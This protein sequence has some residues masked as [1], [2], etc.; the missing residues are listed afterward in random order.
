M[1]IHGE[2]DLAEQ[3]SPATPATGRAVVYV[4]SDGRLYIKDDTGVERL[5]TVA[6]AA[7]DGV[8]YV[9]AGLLANDTNDGLTWSSPKATVASAVSSLP[10]G[11]GLVK[12]SLGTFIGPIV[13]KSN[14][15]IEGLGPEMT[16]LTIANGA[17]VDVV[18]GENFDTLTRTESNGGIARWGLRNLTIDG[19]KANQTAELSTPAAPALSSATTGGS[20]A[21]ATHSYRI[22]RVNSLGTTLP[23]SVTTIATT[24]ST[25]TVTVTFPATV[26]GQTGWKVYANR[27][28]GV[29]KLVT[30][31]GLVA[32]YADNGSVTPAG[33]LPDA[34]GTAA[35][36]IRSYGYDFSWD[37]VVVRN[38]K[39]WGVYSE[40]AAGNFEILGDG[41]ESHVS[42]FSVHNNEGGGIAWR[43]P[44]DSVW[45]SGVVFKN[46]TSTAM[47][48][49]VDV[50]SGASGLR[51]YGVHVWGADCHDWAWY[52]HHTGT[53]D[54]TTI[55]LTDCIGEGGET[56]NLIIG[57]NDCSV[58]GGSYFDLGSS[59][60]PMGITVGDGVAVGGTVLLG[61]KILN[62]T[63]GAITYANDAGSTVVLD[64]YQTGG[65]VE[66]GSP[67][68][69]SRIDIRGNGSRSK[70]PGSVEATAGFSM[71]AG[72][73]LTSGTT[74]PVTLYRNAANQWR[75]DD[76]LVVVR[77]AVNAFE[78]W[79]TV[80]NWGIDTVNKVM[81]LLNGAQIR[82][83]SDQFGT[84]KYLIDAASG[85]AQFTASADSTATV[86]QGA[87]AGLGIDLTLAN[88]FLVAVTGNMTSG[89]PLQFPIKA[90]QIVTVQ[91]AQ[92][93]TGG[94]T[95]ILPTEADGS[96]V[97]WS[98]STP[99]PPTGP[100]AR[101]SVTLYWDGFDWWEIGRSQNLNPAGASAAPATDGV[102]YVS[103]TGSDSN[104]GLS[105][106]SAKLTPRAAV[107]SLAGPG[108]VYIGKGTFSITGPATQVVMPTGVVLQG[109]GI[110]STV[111]QLAA[112]ANVDA[113]KGTNFDTLRGTNGTGGVYGW[114]IRDLTIDVN[115]TNQSVGLS[116]PAAPT[117]GTPAQALVGGSLVPGVYRYRLADRNAVGPT[118]ASA[119]YVITVAAG[120]NTNVVNLVLPAAGAGAVDR[121]I[122]R[123]AV[124]GAAE[125]EQLIATVSAAT[126]TYQDTGATAP[127]GM[128]PITNMSKPAGVRVYGYDFTVENVRIRN[129]GWYSEWTNVIAGVSVADSME[130][131]IH[132]LKVHDA[133]EDGFVFNGPHDTSIVDL[134]SYQNI[135]VGIFVGPNGNA[136]FVNCHSWGLKQGEAWRIRATGVQL[137]NCVGEGAAT[138]Q[139][140][141]LGNDLVVSGGY[142]FGASVST[143][144]QQA[145]ASGDAVPF[146]RN[147]SSNADFAGLPT[148]FQ[149]QIDSED[150][151]VSGTTATTMTFSAR[152][153]NGTVAAAH[154]VGA[155]IQAPANPVGF[156]IGNTDTAVAGTKI[157]TKVNNCTSGTVRFTN[158]AGA[159]RIQI[160]GYQT[161]GPAVV[162]SPAAST[163][164]GVELNGGGTGS[165]S[166]GPVIA[167][168]T[169]GQTV[170]AT[171][172]ADDTHLSLPVMANAEYEIEVTLWVTAAATTTGAAVSLNGPASPTF[173]QFSAFGQI[174]QGASGAAS[175]IFM[176]SATA[177]NTIL[178]GASV[179]STTV[180]SMVVIKGYLSNGATAGN[181]VVRIAGEAA[182]SITYRQGSMMRLTR[183]A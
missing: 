169:A 102:R 60:A 119:A 89:N 103:A 132:N 173:L 14:V 108:I 147:I 162:G 168:K 67:H 149:V 99:V 164:L 142:Y 167:R 66:A 144:L 153:Q 155:N 115:G 117:A 69:T 114:A 183:I 163:K 55:A 110:G 170:S 86:A 95:I 63:S 41:S 145:I 181:L 85:N 81:A 70:F 92:D 17:N 180:P 128:L 73:A 40:W 1:R 109:A 141:V 46:G 156:Q 54:A 2:L 31:V 6:P 159:S 58:I 126:T 13:A 38:C 78:V 138:A 107:D 165:Q 179:A 72:Q 120:T 80:Q 42:N 94:R 105:P 5:F 33:R 87:G 175:T 16:V 48:R 150:F 36:G 130:A 65:T 34:N 154:S 131:S 4:K 39:G 91:F 151:T 44:H 18:K 116:T 74:D 101:C 9:S 121:L 59:A 51:A 8:R 177:Y 127:S 24:G 100:F 3:T 84:L 30:E 158:D 137:A 56:G 97:I 176:G 19:N 152:A 125:T 7:A 29:E 106:G 11:G 139:V 61:A 25:S 68:I 140:M 83:Y 160:T 161:F 50:H 118:L 143:T 133:V 88:T 43:G 172:L 20:L 53:G 52:L 47:R 129:G 104:N 98:G 64:V 57:D 15:V 12:V 35:A 174:T 32:S 146:T 26:A 21:A 157:D 166:I 76:S 123:S 136:Q 75:T 27:G 112:S 171:S 28:S 134:I 37:N 135:G 182:A 111:L 124:G 122:F 93:A 49:G 71:P 22:V 113:I 62:C 10:A 90:G 178:L 82:G 23:S 45:T 96:A 79:G 77:E 148:P